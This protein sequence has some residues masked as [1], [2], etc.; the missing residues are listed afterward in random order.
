MRHLSSTVD[1]VARMRH[2]RIRL[3]TAAAVDFQSAAKQS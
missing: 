3:A 2:D 1:E